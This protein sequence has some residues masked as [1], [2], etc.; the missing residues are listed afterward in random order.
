MHNNLLFKNGY[1]ITKNAV[2]DSYI[3]NWE[4]DEFQGYCIYTYPKLKKLKYIEASAKIYLIGIVLD[5]FNQ[6]IDE[7]SILKRLSTSLSESKESFFNYL[8][9]LSGRFVLLVDGF[10][11][12]FILQD[13]TGSRTVFYDKKRHTFS[14][15]ADI[16]ARI[17][18]YDI[19]N[20]ARNLI[21]SDAYKGN[22]DS[23]FP[24]ISTPYN[25]VKMLTPN[26]LLNF[27]NDIFVERFFPREDLKMNHLDSNF[28]NES[29]EFFTNQI[30]LLN[31]K[32]KL[33]ISLT[34]GLDSRLTLATAN[35]IK[36]S[37]LA[38]TLIYGEDSKKDA[39]VA[40]TLSKNLG[41]N[42]LIIDT[43]Q[44]EH[45]NG[46]NE[47]FRI[48]TSNM[49][50]DFRSRIGES[51]LKHYPSDYLHIKSN[52]S[53]I[54]RGYY[55]EL[56]GMLPNKISAE[57]Y[58]KLYGIQ[59]K[60]KFVID[61][62]Q[63]YINISQ[64]D[65]E[66]IFNYDPYD[67]LYWEYRI[68]NWQSLCLMEWDV[69]QDT[70]IPYNNRYILMKMMSLPLQEKL[71]GTLYYKVIDRIWPEVMCVPINPF[72]NKNK[73]TGKLKYMLKGLKFRVR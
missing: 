1:L 51:I 19:S 11:E 18:G 53:E 44:D 45:T 57:N 66:K 65:S 29:T 6:E 48:N 37:I 13:A 46:F 61:C 36:D 28:I 33:A 31:Q 23:H 25:E 58:A 27:T 63:E 8:D 7:M 14:S 35:H 42:H 17:N 40:Q 49:S 52:T 70:F 5:V 43:N 38:Y 22:K 26:T 59:G 2:N 12:R 68:G 54:A 62:F 10:G 50:S 21:E 56:Y 60:S 20:E 64:L 71:N 32:Y 4:K 15:H 55:K 72:S 67:L 41:I 3:K 16:I 34:A 73:P 69:A 30:A 39:E 9:T 47:V 24:G